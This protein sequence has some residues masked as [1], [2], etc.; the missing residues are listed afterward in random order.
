MK[1][2]EDIRTVTVDLVAAIAEGSEELARR[3]I[4]EIRPHTPDEVLSQV[5]VPIPTTAHVH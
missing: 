2:H 4:R 5:A 1:A 3:A